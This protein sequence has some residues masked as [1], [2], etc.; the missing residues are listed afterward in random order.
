MK[1]FRFIR[2]KMMLIALCQIRNPKK[3]GTYQDFGLR[4]MEF[5]LAYMSVFVV[6]ATAHTSHGQ[7]YWYPDLAELNHSV[8]VWGGQAI[9][10]LRSQDFSSVSVFS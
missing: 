2:R 9:F 1:L 6:R 3:I 4:I 10:Y 5:L 8:L 7:G